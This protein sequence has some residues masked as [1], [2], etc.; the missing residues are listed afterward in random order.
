MRKTVIS[1]V[2]ANR[3]DFYLC[4]PFLTGVKTGFRIKTHLLAHCSHH[5]ARKLVTYPTMRQFFTFTAGFHP[6]RSSPERHRHSQTT[7]TADLSFPFTIV[8]M[9]TTTRFVHVSLHFQPCDSSARTYKE[10][11]HQS[12]NKRTVDLRSISPLQQSQE[13][14]SIDSPSS[15]WVHSPGRIMPIAH[16]VFRNSSYAAASI[17][18]ATSSLDT[19]E[20]TYR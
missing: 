3:S 2:R 10:L 5:F 15:I 11:H 13:T 1:H 18:A 7:G 9:D 8:A 14:D 6:T 4:R 19:S 17:R 16:S 20:S 12:K